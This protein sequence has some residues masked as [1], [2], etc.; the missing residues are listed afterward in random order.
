MRGWIVVAVSVLLLAIVFSIPAGGQS[1]D[2][3]DVKNVPAFPGGDK[4]QDLDDD[5]LY[6]DVNGDGSVDILDTQ[7]L[8]ANLGT[9]KVQDNAPAFDFSDISATGEVTIFDVAAHWLNY[10]HNG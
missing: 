1:S 8:F 10:V 4:P 5:C 6:E 7:T 2:S 3:C 9:S